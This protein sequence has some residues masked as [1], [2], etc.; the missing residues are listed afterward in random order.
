MDFKNILN[1][2]SLANK[3]IFSFINAKANYRNER[4]LQEAQIDASKRRETYDKLAQI[5]QK[6]SQNNAL[7][8]ERS[9]LQSI[10]A[11]DVAVHRFTSKETIKLYE[12]FLQQLK[13]KWKQY[14]QR[15]AEVELSCSELR[16]IAD[17][18]TG[19]ILHEDFGIQSEEK[20]E[21][22]KEI[23]QQEKNNY[24]LTYEEIASFISRFGKAEKNDH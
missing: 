13:T 17:E 8:L 5:L 7:S 2:D 11:L 16:T 4:S 19:K 3:T 9:T 15:C 6:L 21:C 1:I 18:E 23:C 12:D 24:L 20:E 14:K 10:K 22:Y